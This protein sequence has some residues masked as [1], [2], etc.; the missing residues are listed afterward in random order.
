MALL[1]ALPNALAWVV[2][3]ELYRNNSIN[4]F[5]QGNHSLLK[6]VGSLFFWYLFLFCIY[7]AF[8]L[9]KKKY[10][11][12]VYDGTRETQKK[13]FS[14]RF[15]FLIL[16]ILYFIEFFLV[17]LAYYPGIFSYDITIQTDQALGFA[18]L[19]RFH[20]VLHT[21]FWKVCIKLGSLIGN[22]KD[23]FGIKSALLIYSVLQSLILACVLAFGVCRIMRKSRTKFLPM[24]VF[25]LFAFHPVLLLF[26]IIPTKDALFACFFLMFLYEDW[27][28]LYGNN[29]NITWKQCTPLVLN[30]SVCCLLRNNAVYAFLLTIP[31]SVLILKSGKKKY[32]ASLIVGCCVYFLINGPVYSLFQIKKGDFREAMCV[33]FQQLAHTY[34]SEREHL[35]EEER[36]NYA[37]Y[38]DQD[39]LLLF[40]PRFADYSKNAVIKDALEEDLGGFL[41]FYLHMFLKYPDNYVNA[42]LSL[43]VSGWY[44]G[45]GGIDP[46]AEREYVETVLC[47]YQGYQMER[48][49]KLP[50][51]YSFLEGIAD[52]STLEKI[53]ILKNLFSLSF[54]FW[55]LWMVFCLFWAEKNKG[56]CL[57]C[58][59]VLFYWLTYLAGPV[60]AMRYYYPIM[61]T[62][63]VFLGI[64]F[65]EREES[66]CGFSQNNTGIVQE[67][68]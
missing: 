33:P 50:G 39:A 51:F 23:P 55:A 47:N 62:L 20:P 28:V 45:A 19:N 16:A 31:F 60:V 21:L 53:P 54:P 18:T 58:L 26:S 22:G 13:R 35:S 64:L 65:S 4:G 41:K 52:F 5:F 56:G 32:V 44:P 36:K 15:L 57:I 11:H 12:K 66:F 37:F 59:P 3:G 43:N 6:A 63:P 25:C 8:F 2:G 24:L 67:K 42:F 34:L 10:N 17:Y 38:F 7:L 27:F 48:E 40:N 46:Y 30:I 14:G 1:A 68:H 61:L 29:D 9:I 49:S